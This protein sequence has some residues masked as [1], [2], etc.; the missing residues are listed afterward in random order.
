V[1]F[2]SVGLESVLTL[3]HP[4][5]SGIVQQ[6]DYISDSLGFRVAATNLPAAPVPAESEVKTEEV[7]IP[8]TEAP[9]I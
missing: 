5:F 9:G 8:Q 1:H 7:E 6:V 2:K 3:K 4:H